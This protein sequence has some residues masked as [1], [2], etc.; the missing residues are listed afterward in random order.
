MKR[1]QASGEG[2]HTNHPKP[3]AGVF[4][5]GNVGTG[6]RIRKETMQLHVIVFS[7]SIQN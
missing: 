4:A 7:W 2:F 1:G 6:P 3:R 5:Q